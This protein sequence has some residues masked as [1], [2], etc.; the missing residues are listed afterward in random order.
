MTAFLLN[1]EY[2]ESSSDSRVSAGTPE[3]KMSNTFINALSV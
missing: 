2:S 3:L 1:S